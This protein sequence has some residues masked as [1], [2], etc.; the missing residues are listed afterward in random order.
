MVWFPDCSN[1]AKIFSISLSVANLNSIE[2]RKGTADFSN[3]R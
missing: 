3:Q 1:K 2:Q